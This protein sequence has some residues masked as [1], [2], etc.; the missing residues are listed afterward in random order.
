MKFPHLWTVVL[1]L[2]SFHQSFAQTSTFTQTE[3]IIGTSYDPDLS[4]LYTSGRGY[5]HP[6]DIIRYQNIKNAHFNLLNSKYQDFEYNLRLAYVANIKLIFTNGVNLVS[7]LNTDLASYPYLWNSLYGIKIADEPKIAQF[8]AV[9]TEVA[10]IVTAYPN[11]LAYINLEGGDGSGDGTNIGRSLFE[12]TLDTYL[13]PTGSNIKPDVASFDYYPF[14]DDTYCTSSPSNQGGKDIERVYIEHYFY[15]LSTVRKKAGSRPLWAYPLS[16]DHTIAGTRN[17]AL[18]STRIYPPSTPYAAVNCNVATPHFYSFN[19]TMFMD[20][21]PVAYGAKGLMY[22]TYAKAYPAWGDAIVTTGLNDDVCNQRYT[23]IKNINYYL[24]QVVGPVVM[25]STWLGAYHKSNL[26][27]NEASLVAGGTLE[28][29]LLSDVSNK[30]IA[31][32]NNDNILFGIF[33]KNLPPGTY[34]DHTE[35]QI[36]VVNKSLTSTP[37]NVEIKLKKYWSDIAVSPQVG[38]PPTV[39]PSNPCGTFLNNGQP[40]SGS[41][42]YTGTYGTYDM[43]LNTT[44]FQIDPLQGGEGRLIKI[45]YYPSQPGCCVANPSIP[46]LRNAYPNPASSTLTVDFE[47]PLTNPIDVNVSLTD[48]FGNT[49][50][51]LWAGV[52]SASSNYTSTPYNVS[53]L[54]NGLYYVK[55]IATGGYADFRRIMVQH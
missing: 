7:L 47:N 32:V 2:V 35:Y 10:N 55:M 54:P 15:N 46:G 11:K 5:S 33:R 41:T 6:D 26:P 3:F 48:E 37:G 12:S 30:L 1:W 53:S 39:D 43:F 16:A 29:E 14:K 22:F 25:N 24:E 20:F 36:L 49:I 44:T 28:N 31:D 52:A 34:S 19:K 18:F 17:S 38:V 13:N 9:Q 4:G 50:S 27:T 40:Y 51:I 8:S 23:D 42:T 21:C 45:K